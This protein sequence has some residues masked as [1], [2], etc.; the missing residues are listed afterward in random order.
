[1]L[2]V[3]EANAMKN[4][5]IKLALILALVPCVLI[6]FEP[7]QGNESSFED[8]PLSTGRDFIQENLSLQTVQ[9][10]KE[11]LEILSRLPVASTQVGQINLLTMPQRGLPEFNKKCE[12]I[13]ELIMRGADINATTEFLTPVLYAVRA[14]CDELLEWLIDAGADVNKVGTQFYQSPLTFAVLKNDREM[15]AKLI[16]AGA[17]LDYQNGD[18]ATALMIAARTN[19]LAMVSL[20]LNAGADR[21]I[22]NDIDLTAADIAIARQAANRRINYG[23]VIDLLTKT[24]KLR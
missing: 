1:M 23:A 14:N 5:L 21:T 10:N 8:Q 20:L 7:P 24:Q 15:A 4:L 3:L 11:L 9:A 16:A 13:K 2:K 17:T 18:S 22:K 12:K 19:N 6:S